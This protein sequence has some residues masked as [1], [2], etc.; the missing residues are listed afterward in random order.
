MV[1]R[2]KLKNAKWEVYTTTSDGAAYIYAVKGLVGF[3]ETGLW[4]VYPP[5]FFEKLLGIT[6]DQKLSKAYMKAEKFV[7]KLNKKED[8]LKQALEGLK[9][10]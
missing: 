7:N 3:L 4:V 9:E 2:P 10:K 8:D 5:S 1:W 6:F